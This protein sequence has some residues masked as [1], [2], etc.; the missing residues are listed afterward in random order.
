MWVSMSYYTHSSP[1][2]VERFRYLPTEPGLAESH[3]SIELRAGLVAGQWTPKAS[4]PIAVLAAELPPIRVR[5]LTHT[6]GLL[7]YS[8][9][10]VQR[11]TLTMATMLTTL[12]KP[13]IL[14]IVEVLPIPA[15]AASFS[16]AIDRVR[17]VVDQAEHL[18]EPPCDRRKDTRQLEGKMAFVHAITFYNDQSKPLQTLRARTL[19][20]N[21]SLV[22]TWCEGMRRG[23]ERIVTQRPD[24]KAVSLSDGEETLHKLLDD[25][26]ASAPRLIDFWHVVEK[27]GTALV[28]INLA[29]SV[30]SCDSATPVPIFS[31]SIHAFHDR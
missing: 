15:E 14:E 1:V 17:L 19:A 23:V 30:R 18:P 20:H 3:C 24:L 21:P 5:T 6:L 25:L 27:L 9:S 2:S 22:E 16:V 12:K 29:Q 8:L 13:Q 31:F 7:P 11:L 10:I 28:A 26:L 4:E